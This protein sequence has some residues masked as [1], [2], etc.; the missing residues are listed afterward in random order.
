LLFFYFY[1]YF[2]FSLLFP[3]LSFPPLDIE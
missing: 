1:F 3:S 2:F